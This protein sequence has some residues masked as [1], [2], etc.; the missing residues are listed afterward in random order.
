MGTTRRRRE[1]GPFA[2][3]E[4]Q[5]YGAPGISH[6]AGSLTRRSLL[7]GG[8]AAAGA[9]L[10]SCAGPRPARAAGA[11]V[12]F[13]WEYGAGY[14]LGASSRGESTPEWLAA[15]PNTSGYENASVMA[16]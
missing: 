12:P 7:A 15:A 10:W 8:G 6:S 11:T 9:A 5:T 14:G 4:P 3:S 1:R 2:G 16:P 13:G